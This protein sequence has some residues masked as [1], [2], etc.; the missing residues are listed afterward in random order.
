MDEQKL[1]YELITKIESAR[2]AQSELFS[3][4]R[5]WYRMYHGILPEKTT[6]WR[7]ASNLHIPITQIIVDTI[8][9]SLANAILNNIPIVAVIPYQDQAV[10]SP[11]VEESARRLESFLNYA[12]NEEI[13]DFRNVIVQWIRQAV[14]YGTGI[15][16][17]IW[18]LETKNVRR[19]GGVKIAEDGSL[20]EG[21]RTDIV[22]VYDAP[23]LSVVDLENFIIPSYAT[24]IQD[25]P[26]V[27]ERLFIPI[28]VLK[29]RER[30]GFYK[31]VDEL[32]T[33]M[34]QERDVEAEANK[35]QG[36]RQPPTF[37]GVEVY[38]Y[39]GGAD[40]DGDGYEEEYHIVLAAHQPKILR[41]EEFPYYHNRRPYVAYAFLSEPNRFWGYGIAQQ[42]QHLQEEI[43]AI[44]NQRMDN[45]NLIIN[46]VF[47]Y[48]PNMYF[49]NAEDIVFAPGA[50]IPVE[51]MNDIQPLITSDVPISSYNEEQIVR[52]Y[53]ERV[54]GITDFTLGRIPTTA[55]RTPATL[56]IAVIS[57]GNKRMQ[58]RLNSLRV[59]LEQVFDMVQWLYYQFMPPVKY[60][61]VPGGKVFQS[62]TPEDLQYQYRFNI[63]GSDVSVSK[64]V[65]FQQ[66]LQLFSLLSRVGSIAQSPKIME[67]L[68]KQLI[69]NSSFPNV[70]EILQEVASTGN[71]AVAGGRATG[72]PRAGGVP[73][74]QDL[75]RSILGGITGIQGAAEGGLS[76]GR[77]GFGPTTPELGLEE[78]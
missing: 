8:T 74:P 49:E 22:K 59:A 20:I 73:T 12:I 50:K 1:W 71:L 11:E 35:Y 40:L 45:I 15:V 53:I 75:L 67:Y 48:R 29:Q 52:D 54:T 30:E 26:F 31:N 61:R 57:E 68:T 38:D 2:E 39:W 9:A 60:F 28:S 27:A 10:Q 7:G 32:L 51:D 34:Y 77:P 62:I 14:L 58:E 4:F 70:E 66:A 3:N 76:T 23:Y 43:N 19:R 21:E 44:H 72:E 78:A 69:L 16:K 56:G 41:I 47:K 37:E 36:L 18:R 6:P 5:K 63:T 33:S 42:I 17:V 13:P 25:A 64:D 55:R 46:K 65:R 24:N